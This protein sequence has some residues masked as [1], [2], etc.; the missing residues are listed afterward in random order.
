MGISGKG[1]ITSLGIKS[2]ARPKKYKKSRYSIIN[3]SMNDLSNIIREFEKLPHRS[4]DRRRPK[5]EPTES[6]FYPGRYIEKCMMRA[7]DLNSHVY[8][9]RT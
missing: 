4:Y 2:K 7:D 6:Y 3:V 5:H 8:D 9:V 1:F